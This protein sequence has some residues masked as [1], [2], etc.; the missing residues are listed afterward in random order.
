MEQSRTS[1]PGHDQR[2]GFVRIGGGCAVATGA[3]DFTFVR[4]GGPG[5]QHVN[6]TSTKAQLR[7]FFRDLIGLDDAG[8][9]RLREI[10]GSHVVGDGADEALLISDQTSRSQADNREACLV[11]FKTLVAMAAKKPKV[12][13]KTKPTRGSKER[14]L[15]AKKREGEKKR[16]RGWRE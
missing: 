1:H 6:K 8:F 12:R 7:V 11:R 9:A 10:G 3:L 14:R 2:G 16:E 4:G 13:K 5:G 15:E